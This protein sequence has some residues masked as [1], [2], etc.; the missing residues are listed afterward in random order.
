MFYCKIC[1]SYLTKQELLDKHI[2][3]F[4]DKKQSREICPRKILIS[5]AKNIIKNY[6]RL[7]FVVYADFE[8]FTN[9]MNNCEPDLNK[10]YTL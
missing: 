9:P 4:S 3:C 7:P 10:S 5:I 6:L 1:L 2:T 8:C